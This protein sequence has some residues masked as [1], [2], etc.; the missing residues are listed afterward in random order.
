MIIKFTSNNVN[1]LI[2]GPLS[3]KEL[4]NREDNIK[5]DLSLSFI[6]PGTE[7]LS[8]DELNEETFLAVKKKKAKERAKKDKKRWALIKAG[9]WIPKGKGN[10]G[11]PNNTAIRKVHK[12]FTRSR[13]GPPQSTSK[14]K[15][16]KSRKHQ[17][18]GSNWTRKTD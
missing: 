11:T 18:R 9:K 8:D 17:D 3:L 13:L 16:K 5:P 4:K 12:A 7:S 10:S 14:G 6:E 2:E 1:Y 15:G